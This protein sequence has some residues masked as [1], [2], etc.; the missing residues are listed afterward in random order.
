MVVY[1][2]GFG[3]IDGY[4]ARNIHGNMG[5]ISIPEGNWIQTTD[6]VPNNIEH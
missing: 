1:M 3:Q 5:H 2:E 4:D 6:T